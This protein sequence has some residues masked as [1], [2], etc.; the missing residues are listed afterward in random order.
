VLSNLKNVY[1]YDELPYY[2]KRQNSGE[3]FRFYN[4]LCS[5]VGKGG[6]LKRVGNI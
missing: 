2:E 6:V 3:V 4:S 1:I 5:V